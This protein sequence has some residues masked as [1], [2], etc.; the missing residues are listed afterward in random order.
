[1]AGN[2]ISSNAA[3]VHLYD[4]ARKP[5]RWNGRV[6][7]DVSMEVN[8]YHLVY[9]ADPTGLYFVAGIVMICTIAISNDDPHAS[10]QVQL[11]YD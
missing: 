8:P 3:W 2:G 1:M 4:R 5:E 10:C 6:T 7:C 9:M 11:A